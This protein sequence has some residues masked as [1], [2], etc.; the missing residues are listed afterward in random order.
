MARCANPSA[1]CS[2]DAV[3]RTYAVLEVVRQENGNFL[4]PICREYQS[5]DPSD[6]R[7]HCKTCDD[8]PYGPILTANWNV[9]AP[10]SPTDSG[11]P[12]NRGG[13]GW[14]S[15]FSHK[16]LPGRKC[17]TAEIST[18]SHKGHT[19]HATKSPHHSQPLQQG[20]PQQIVTSASVPEYAVKH[21]ATSVAPSQS[22]SGMSSHVNAV[23]GPSREPAVRAPATRRRDSSGSESSRGALSHTRRAS[24]AMSETRRERTRTAEACQ[25]PIFRGSFSPERSLTRGV[26]RRRRCA[27]NPHC[28]SLASSELM[29]A[30]YPVATL[31]KE[32]STLSLTVVSLSYP[33]RPPEPA[34]RRG[35]RG[36]SAPNERFLAL[37]TKTDCPHCLSSRRHYL[38]PGPGKRNRLC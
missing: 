38:L 19:A 36:Q 3:L 29:I 6:I 31:P 12:A 23:A 7:K 1:H 34:L 18:S 22:F 33:L 14:L 9:S 30:G 4:C 17:V 35:R 5:Q 28:Q 21:P 15:A 13:D 16:T 20:Y 25:I 8:L 27:P 32:S 24:L 26:S 2:A 11:A 10:P 37:R